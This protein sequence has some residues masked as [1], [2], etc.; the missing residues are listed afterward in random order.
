MEALEGVLKCLQDHGIKVK[1]SKC[2]FF[3]KGIEYLGHRIDASGLHPTI[4]KMEAVVN[5]PKPR[6]MSELKSY[7]GL[8]N[9]Y[10]R[11]MPNL[12]TTLQPLQCK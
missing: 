11:F 10:S 3:Q 8:L 5:A 2:K 9:Y 12:S 7:L 1:L 4:E 6:N